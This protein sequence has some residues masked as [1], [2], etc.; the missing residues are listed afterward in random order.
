MSRLDR[1]FYIY[2]VINIEFISHDGLPIRVLSLV[3]EGAREGKTPA[4]LFQPGNRC[5]L[6][7][8]MWLFKPLRAAGYLVYG[9]HQRGYGSGPDG[10]NDRGGP[11]H[12]EDLRRALEF[13]KENPLVDASRITC[14]GHSN[15]GH[16]V[17]RMAAIYGGFSRLVALSQISDW[18]L[19]IRS[20]KTYLPDYYAKVVREF[21]GPPEENPAPYLERS[22]L[23]LADK[24]TLPVLAVVGGE[25]T[26]TPPH[27]S[28]NMV[29]ALRRAGNDRAELVVIPGVG[30]FFENYGF[31]GY[32][33]EEVAQAV[34]EW[35]G[36]SEWTMDNGQWG[37]A[38]LLCF[39]RNDGVN[40]CEAPDGSP[41]QASKDADEVPLA[42]S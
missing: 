10:V 25:D 12:Q 7:G 29:D 9:I 16:M 6:D 31:D 17:Q 34:L 24:I 5:A 39:A 30:H 27:L 1:R 23:H 19:F 15:G 14:I 28:R 22:C 4:V 35:M 13:L 38:G 2:G 11:I 26:T 20:A 37:N 32:K 41:E 18:E 40:G 21:G 36:R 42:D 33:T 8:Y 3:P